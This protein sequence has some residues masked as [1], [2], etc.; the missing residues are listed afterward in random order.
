M[1]STVRA[2][3]R[4]EVGAILSAEIVL[5][6]TILVL[7]MLVGL[8]E[9]QCSLVDELNDI[10]EAI[11]SLNQSYVASG[12]AS[13]KKDGT[14]KA[15]NFGSHFTDRVDSCDGN[16]CAIVCIAPSCAEEPKGDS[17]PQ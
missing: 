8:V 4:D 2:L 10:G 9:L 16:E 15:V 14:P 12:S 13:F 1:L 6:G 17:G 5:V 7:G 3:Y 11:G